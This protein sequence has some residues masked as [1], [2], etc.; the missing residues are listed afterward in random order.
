MY[1]FLN[2]TII[3]FIILILSNGCMN[4]S[5]SNEM[6]M[7]EGMVIEAFRNNKKIIIINY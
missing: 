5:I 3:I 1:S 4:Q 6:A 7:S 2:K